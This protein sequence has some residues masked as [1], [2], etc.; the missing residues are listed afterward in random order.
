ME[1]DA[2]T[3]LIYLVDLLFGHHSRVAPFS[4]FITTMILLFIQ[5]IIPDVI[6]HH[7]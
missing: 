3:K 6:S 5:L 4:I 1:V 2:S 7:S